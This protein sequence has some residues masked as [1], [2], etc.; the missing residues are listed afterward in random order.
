MNR[1]TFISK[2]QTLRLPKID[3]AALASQKPPKISEYLRGE[4]LPSNVVTKIEAAINAVE[5]VQ[6]CLR[7]AK[8]DTSDPEVFWRVYEMMVDEGHFEQRRRLDKQMS[9]IAKQRVAAIAA[10]TAELIEAV[11]E[12]EA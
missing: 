2:I 4:N 7:P 10:D 6:N 3:L 1:E 9:E 12:F 8:L 11:G 5:A